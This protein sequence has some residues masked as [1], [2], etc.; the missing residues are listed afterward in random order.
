MTLKNRTFE[1]LPTAIPGKAGFMNPVGWFSISLSKR[2][3][4]L[5]LIEPLTENSTFPPVS[6]PVIRIAAST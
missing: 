4:P 3:N 5:V 2:G 6:I 1:L